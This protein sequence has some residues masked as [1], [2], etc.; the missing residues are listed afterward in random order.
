MPLKKLVC[1]TPTAL[2][3]VGRFIC[4]VVETIN[5]VLVDLSMDVVVQKCRVCGGLFI[6]DKIGKVT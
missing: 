3:P 5:Y 4:N 6:I 2:K 1:C